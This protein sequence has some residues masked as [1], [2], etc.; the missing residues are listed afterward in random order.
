MAQPFV[1]QNQFMGMWRDNPRDQ[2][3]S[4]RLWNSVDLIP[5]QLGAP[6]R[7]RG[8]WAYGSPALG[9]TIYVEGLISAT[10]GGTAR[11]FA[12]ATDTVNNAHLYSFTS[13]VSST[14]I[15][16]IGSIYVLQN[17]VLHRSGTTPLIVIPCGAGGSVVKSYD[18]TTLGNLG[19]SP[20][21]ANYADV[22]LDRTI[23][24]YCNVSSTNYLQRIYFGPIGDSAATWDTT[25]AWTDTTGDIK[26][27]AVIRSGILAFHD[28]TTDIITG[29]TAPSATSVG[30]LQQRTNAFQVGCIDAR[31]I[32][33]F[34]DTAIWANARGVYQS[35]GNTVK[36]LTASGGISRYWR[37]TF[38]GL[39]ITNVSYNVTGGIYNNTYIVSITSRSGSDVPTTG[40]TLD[41]LA[42][43][44]ANN[45][46]YRL[47]NCGFGAMAQKLTS[48]ADETFMGLNAAGRV[49]KASTMLLPTSAVKND[50]DGTAVTPVYET[51]LFRGFSRFHRKYVQSMGLQSWVRFYLNY[52]I[53]DAATDN[54]YLTV[55]YATD[56]AATSYTDLSPTFVENSAYQ[57]ARIDLHFQA[58]GVMFKVAQTNASA[59]TR[60]HAIEVEYQ[61]LE[62]SRLAQ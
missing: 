49:A 4:G 12:I 62:G 60:L 3:P 58:N 56:P 1:I 22:W 26:G 47:G 7:K 43:D 19:G 34:N 32:A 37:D 28:H 5:E 48:Q 11:D 52:E 20:P 8:G 13:S 29:T 18:G 36:D 6:T 41:C 2:V 31:S 38:T 53:T 46:W 24:G 59:D 44:I 39:P 51:G 16:S 55:S 57:R 54:P 61:P 21:K 25:N 10:V 9:S 14:D 42:Y 17:P 15:G 50:G 45:Y 35:D 27:L 23:L 33:K 40:A 30:D